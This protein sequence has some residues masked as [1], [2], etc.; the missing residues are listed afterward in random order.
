LNINFTSKA[1]FHPPIFGEGIVIEKKGVGYE[2]KVE[3]M[4]RTGFNGGHGKRWLEHI[5][6]SIEQP[7]QTDQNPI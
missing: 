4:G 6:V 3:W 5:E 7:E 2:G 1:L